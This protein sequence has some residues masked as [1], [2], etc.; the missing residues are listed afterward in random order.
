MA[1]V[2]LVDIFAVGDVETFPGLQRNG[3]IERRRLA[4]CRPAGVSF[5]CA[6]GDYPSGS[7]ATGRKG[8]GHHREAA[9]GAIERG[10]T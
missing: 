3:S 5:G 2:P 4:A 1:A 7:P 10:K 9:M 6:T 8:T